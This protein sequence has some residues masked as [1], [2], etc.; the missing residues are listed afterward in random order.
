MSR[1]KKTYPINILLAILILLASFS[2]AKESDPIVLKVGEYELR[3]STYQ[4]ILL[5]NNKSNTISRCF[6]ENNIY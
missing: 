2:C 1:T 4:A 3:N 6:K 5:K